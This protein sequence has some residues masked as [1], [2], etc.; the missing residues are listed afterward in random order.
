MQYW[1]HPVWQTIATLL[2][3][4]T[5]HLAVPRV[6]AA[7]FGQRRAFAWKNHVRLGTWALILWI[8][9][10]ALGILMA[11]I[12]WQAVLITGAHAWAGL[13]IAALSLFGYFTGRHM[14]AV[15]ARRVWLPALHGLN[16]TALIFLAIWQFWTGWAFLP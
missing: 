15:K 10:T 3:A 13:T 1:I 6:L 12:S 8:S 11:Q 16:N 14:D 4:Y 5:L 7:H 2:A 9:G